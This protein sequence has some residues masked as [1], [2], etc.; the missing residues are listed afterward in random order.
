M[1][2]QVAIR[3]L[4]ELNKR[5]LGGISF[6][7]AI[8]VAIEAIT[9]QPSDDYV[10]VVIETKDDDQAILDNIDSE[11]RDDVMIKWNDV[12]N[13]LPNEE[14]E[15][16]VTTFSGGILDVDKAILYI[17]EDGTKDWSLFGVIAWAELPMPYKR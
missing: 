12:N 4:K 3:L 11:L 6:N 7:R 1:N 2:N 8:E 14:C 17:N 10:D 16:L 15:Y 9:K 5:N 13:M